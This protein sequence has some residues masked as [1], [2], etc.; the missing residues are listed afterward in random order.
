MKK[1]LVLIC[2]FLIFTSSSVF[3]YSEQE[4][5]LFY[6]GFVLGFFGELPKSLVANGHSRDKA[7]KYTVA[8]KARLNRQQLEQQTWGC[9]S[10]YGVVEIKAREKELAAKCFGPW[11]TK[12][13]NNN[14]DLY[15]LL[16]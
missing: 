4:K 16:K 14:S 3:A 10:Q 2:A 15:Q 12:F 13:M 5:K 11:V 7:Y 8:L 9:I 1:F 6:D